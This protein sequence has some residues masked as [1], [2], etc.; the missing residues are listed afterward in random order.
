MKLLALVLFLGLGFSS[1]DKEDENLTCISFDIRSCQTD[2]F[3]EAV[4]ESDSVS[5]RES[6]M[7]DWLESK[8]YNV[9][10]IRLHVGFHEAVC[11]ACH[12]CPQGDRYFVEKE[13]SDE[14]INPE[15]LELL[16]FET[17]DCGDAF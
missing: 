8:G 2:Q 10:Q 14:E 3:A 1:C 6:K 9:K 4:P 15:T 12:V 17:L 16:S 7:K 13:D 11:E 5:D